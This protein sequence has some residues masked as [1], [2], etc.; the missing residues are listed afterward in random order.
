M[1]KEICTISIANNS[2]GDNYTFYENQTI[3]RIYDSNNKHLDITEWLTNDQISS[4]SKDKL[5][6]NCPEELKEKIM[7]I[8]N[9]P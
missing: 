3:K 6:K 5:V 9:Y 1:E 8:L 7:L 4:Q 2:L